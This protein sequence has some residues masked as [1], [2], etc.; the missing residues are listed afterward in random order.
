MHAH[1]FEVQDYEVQA[2]ANGIQGAVIPRQGDEFGYVAVLWGGTMTA[3]DRKRLEQWQPDNPTDTGVF[4]IPIRLSPV[5]SSDRFTRGVYCES[6]HPALEQPPLSSPL[7]SL[8]IS[9]RDLPCPGGY[10]FSLGS[11]VNCDRQAS[12]QTALCRENTIELSGSAIFF[13][14]EFAP[15]QTGRECLQIRKN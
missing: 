8:P 7:R 1:Y 15:N 5:P 4:S 13:R 2:I 6:L 12:C 10:V 3:G 9:A 11:F 14:A